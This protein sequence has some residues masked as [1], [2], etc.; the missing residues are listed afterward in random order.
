MSTGY[1]WEDNVWLIPIVDEREI[2][3]E[4]DAV[5][6]RICGGDLLRRG[7]ISSVSTFTV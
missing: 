4:N 3:R 6:E 2:P 1:S 7:A 5:P